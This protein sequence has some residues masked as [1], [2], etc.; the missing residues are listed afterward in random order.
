[1]TKLEIYTIVKSHPKIDYVPRINDENR[2]HL[3]CAGVACNECVF[4]K[5]EQCSASPTTI[6]TKQELN[7]LEFL[8]LANRKTSDD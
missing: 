1:M 2:Y 4:G 8:Y 7:R 3:D 6:H 5:E